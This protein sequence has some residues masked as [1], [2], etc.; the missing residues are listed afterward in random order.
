L[1]D[2]PGFR[3]IKTGV[4]VTAG[5]CLSSWYNNNG[6]NLIVVILDS[7]SKNSRWE[8]TVSLINW[9]I[10]LINYANNIENNAALINIDKILDNLEWDYF[11]WIYILNIV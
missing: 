1:L 6:Y 7:K 9:S 5:P 8:E 2:Y 4:T 3:G 11:D 10:K